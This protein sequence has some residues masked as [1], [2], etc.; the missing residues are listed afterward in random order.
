MHP[1]SA[2]RRGWPPPAPPLLSRDVVP[3]ALLGPLALTVGALLGIGWLARFIVQ[4]IRDTITDL[5]AQRDVAI[6]G[7]RDQTK[8]T[9][10]LAAAVESRNRRDATSKR[11]GD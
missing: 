9:D 1:P 3:D 4:F 6:E 5:K 10:R 8:A 2:P 11:Q 7:W